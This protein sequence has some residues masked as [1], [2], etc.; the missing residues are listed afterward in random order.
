MK[1]RSVAPMKVN[2]A[3]AV[4]PEPMVEAP[5]ETVEPKTTI[6]KPTNFSTPLGMQVLELKVR[7]LKQGDWFIDPSFNRTVTKN[8]LYLVM[9]DGWVSLSGMRASMN[10][11]SLVLKIIKPEIFFIWVFTYQANAFLLG[12]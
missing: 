9:D 3:K 2:R 7:E 5:K 11:D 4:L 12:G 8:T 1:K 10:P 6:Y